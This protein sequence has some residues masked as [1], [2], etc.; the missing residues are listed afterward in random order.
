MNIGARKKDMK[1]N[2]QS[3]IGIALS[4]DTAGTKV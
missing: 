2:K 1:E 3:Y 4:F